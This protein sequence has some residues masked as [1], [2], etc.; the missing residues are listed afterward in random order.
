[1][2][3]AVKGA[4]PADA[5]ALSFA[6]WTGATWARKEAFETPESYFYQ[7]CMSLLLILGLDNWNEMAAVIDRFVPAI[8]IN[9]GQ[10]IDVHEAIASQPVLYSSLENRSLRIAR[11]NPDR[12]LGSQV[13][14]PRGVR[15]SMKR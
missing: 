9:H 2:T 6:A 11:L 3:H 12:R 1:M 4:A 5:S 14:I 13:D 10:H 15:S 7:T 8:M